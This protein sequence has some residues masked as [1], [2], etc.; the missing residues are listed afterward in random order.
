MTYSPERPNDNW[1]RRK[2]VYIV[3]TAFSAVADYSSQRTPSSGK[4]VYFS[5]CLED[6]PAHGSLP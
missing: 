1:T 2:T 4:T 3:Y 6:S 5:T